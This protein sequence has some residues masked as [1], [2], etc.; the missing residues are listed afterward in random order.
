MKD[1][2][3]VLIDED[4]NETLAEILFTF[5]WEETGKNYV[6]FTVGE[7]V[8]A[9]VYEEGEN[10]SGELFPVETDEEWDKIEEMLAA[11]SEENLE[12]EDEDEE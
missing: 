9:A 6:V 8:S 11:F 3:L 1:N 4:G 2:E 10:A 12:G 7:E 5:P